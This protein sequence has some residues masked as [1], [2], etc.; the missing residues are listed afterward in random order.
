MTIPCCNSSSRR[1]CSGILLVDLMVYLA[2]F[3]LIFGMALAAFYEVN[4]NS[5]R[6]SRNAAD[7]VRALRVGEK[8]RA[9]VRAATSQPRIIQSDGE[10]ALVL[11]QP[12][13]EV[14]YLSKGGAV[15]R[16][17]PGKQPMMILPA[18]K[19]STM[20]SDPRLK[21]TAWRWDLELAPSGKSKPTHVPPLF[22]FTAVP[23]ELAERR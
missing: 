10:S 13:G 20:E 22:T 18:V 1:T 12:S 3:T 17:D 6:I 8:W 21:V 9:D 7:M 5:N 4:D 2:L 16:Q 14:R 19:S 15:Y 23:R 11:T